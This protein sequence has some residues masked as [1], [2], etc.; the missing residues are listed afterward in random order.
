MSALHKRRGRVL[1]EFTTDTFDEL[2]GS[3]K[4][5][6][7][8]QVW[9]DPV[10]A[11]SFCDD[12]SVAKR[13]EDDEPVEDQAGAVVH[14]AADGTETPSVPGEDGLHTLGTTE[15]GSDEKA[16]ETKPASKPGRSGKPAESA[17]TVPGTDVPTTVVGG[18]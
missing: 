15:Q 5:R 12:K 7:G 14:V 8:E 9:V 4:R 17:E 3:P 2:D 18:V 6:E 13:V 1:I 11:K 16:A 10:S